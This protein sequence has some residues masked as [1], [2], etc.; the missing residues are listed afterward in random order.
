LE[1]TAEKLKEKERECEPKFYAAGTMKEIEADV[2]ND[3]Q[4]Q[5]R[6]ERKNLLERSLVLKLGKD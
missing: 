2:Q 6:T 3:M 4:K 1:K 5:L